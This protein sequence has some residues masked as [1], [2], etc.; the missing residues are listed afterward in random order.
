MSQGREISIIDCHAGGKKW[1]N[2]LSFFTTWHA[3]N[4]STILT[5]LLFIENSPPGDDAIII[6]GLLNP[7]KFGNFKN[8][9]LK[10]FLVV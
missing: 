2:C 9:M 3:V 5:V 8:R 1:I 7:K 10:F 4:W 6:S